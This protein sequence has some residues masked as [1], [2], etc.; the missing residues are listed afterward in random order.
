MGRN[1]HKGKG[2]LIVD[3][4]RRWAVPASVLLVATVASCA[5]PNANDPNVLGGG[6]GQPQILG[7]NERYVVIKDRWG[8]GLKE[9]VAANYCKKF[10]RIAQFQSR[11]GDAP[12]C[13][14]REANLC[15]TYLCVQ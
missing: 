5:A 9:K 13:S 10:G 15:N 2:G 7:G 14:G 12:G 6:V 3:R 4:I 1:A 8:F 11:G